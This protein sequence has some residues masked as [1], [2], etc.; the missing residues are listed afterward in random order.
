MRSSVRRLFGTDGVRG[1]AGEDVTASL[2]LS[3]GRVAALRCGVERPRVFVIRDTRESGEMLESAIAAG[4]AEAG[5]EVLLGGV[6]PTPAAPL[7]VRRYGFDL[8]VVISASH[9][10]YRDNGIKFFGADGFKLSDADELEIERQL[11]DPTF[12]APAGLGSPEPGIPSQIGRIRPMRGTADDYLRELELRFRDLSLDG[13]DVMLDCANG[14]TYKVAPEIFRRLGASVSVIAD[15]PDGRNINDGCGSTHIQALATAVLAGGHDVGFSFDGDG[16][17]L[18]G[19]D[20]T[21]RVVDG[22]ELLALSA[23]HLRRHGRLSG[24][25]VAVTV[26]TNYG[27]HRAMADAGIEVATTDV[28]DRY[29]LE[30]LRERGWALG[31]EQSGHIIDLGFAPSG[32]GIAAAL[33]ALEA[34][35]GDDLSRRTAMD[36]L[37]QKLVNIRVRDR[38]ALDDAARVQEAIASEAADLLGRGRVLVRSSGTESLVRVMVEAPSAAETTD[39]CGRLAALIEA[40]LA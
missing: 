26:M 29:V 27:F 7:M 28:G 19:V 33:L 1:V 2:A 15:R 17:R 23:L 36:K 24:D 9:N 10:P 32:D 30:A 4:V 31:G 13:V 35:A 25:G 12:H 14:A 6:L 11:D 40:E 37:P 5:G 21:G 22:D 18:L 39:I 38:T 8:A 34:L 16:D 3:L 20:R